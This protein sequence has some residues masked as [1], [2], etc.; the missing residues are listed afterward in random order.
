[1]SVVHVD[2]C[3]ELLVKDILAKNDFISKEENAAKVV[4]AKQNQIILLFIS[5]FL[6]L[7]TG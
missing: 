7:H 2:L 3:T 6:L 4:Y 1:M 5:R